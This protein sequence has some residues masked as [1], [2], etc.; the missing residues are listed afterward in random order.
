MNQFTLALFIDY[1][2]NRFILT[3]VLCLLGAL[4][5]DLY[6]TIKNLNKINISRIL[7]SSL[8]GSITMSALL[9]V[10]N[11]KFS[12][13]VLVCFFTGMWAFKLLEFAMNWNI[14]KAFL[15][16]LFKQSKGVISKTITE[17]I[18]DIEESNKDDDEKSTDKEAKTDNEEEEKEDDDKNN[19]S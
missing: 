7:V 5:K 8:F 16:A 14:V 9:D 19:T 12:I 11:W 13:H 3:F 6:D 4:S 2:Y 18:S 15:K 17:T 1:M 10:V